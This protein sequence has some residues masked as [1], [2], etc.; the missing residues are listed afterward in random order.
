MTECEGARCIFGAAQNER[1]VTTLR[2]RASGFTRNPAT[3]EM[4]RFRL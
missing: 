2:Y 1:Q 4:I 3:N